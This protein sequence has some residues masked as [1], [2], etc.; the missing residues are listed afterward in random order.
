MAGN[1]CVT[2]FRGGSFANGL[3]QAPNRPSG[4]DRLAGTVATY[5]ADPPVSLTE[6]LTAIAGLTPS[7]AARYADP[8]A[9]ASYFGRCTSIETVGELLCSDASI[10]GVDHNWITEARWDLLSVPFRPE[11]VMKTV[12]RYGDRRGDL[13]RL[14]GEQQPNCLA[15]DALTN[16]EVELLRYCTVFGYRVTPRDVDRP[17]PASIADGRVRDE[18]YR[19]ISLYRR[20]SFEVLDAPLRSFYHPETVTPVLSASRGAMVILSTAETVRG[21]VGDAGGSV[22]SSHLMADQFVNASL[23]L[24]KNFARPDQLDGI[25]FRPA[26]AP[27]LGPDEARIYCVFEPA[28]GPYCYGLSTPLEGDLSDETITRFARGHVV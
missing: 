13:A 8:T 28:D 16:C 3:R 4:P 17:T 25:Y 14:F 11:D 27:H 5:L 24:R 23:L 21:L 19:H 1:L 12:E 26:T 2:C 7:V 10:R 20:S 22:V 18:T 9:T 15:L 6:P